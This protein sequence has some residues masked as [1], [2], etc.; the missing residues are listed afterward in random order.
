M[1]MWQLGNC[2][3]SVPNE[4]SL[5]L[6]L[7]SL[8]V[9]RAIR[10]ALP[11]N[12]VA[13][14]RIIGAVVSTLGLGDI[15]QERPMSTGADLLEVNR[16]AWFSGVRRKRYWYGQFQKSANCKTSYHGPTRSASSVCPDL[17]IGCECLTESRDPSSSSGLSG[18][19]CTASISAVSDERH[20]ASSTLPC[21]VTTTSLLTE[22]TTAFCLE[23]DCHLATYRL[24][25]N[26]LPQCTP[27]P[28]QRR[29]LS[30][31]ATRTLGRDRVQMKA[32]CIWKRQSFFHV[33]PGVDVADFGSPFLE[34][35]LAPIPVKSSAHPARQRRVISKRQIMDIILRWS[36][37]ATRSGCR[38]GGTGTS[39][40]GVEHSTER[41]LVPVGFPPHSVQREEACYPRD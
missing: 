11:D 40:V 17:Q 8:L 3:I 38:S 15:L 36:Q 19:L 24:T 28:A 4:G 14:E 6:G 30:I 26:Q 9:Y 33:L 7:I 25:G 13:Q 41:I 31:G 20:R 27:F 5:L 12:P 10:D 21:I 1:A 39:D 34:H 37:E 22:C 23:D 16:V 18:E 29:R 35:S 32:K 2:S